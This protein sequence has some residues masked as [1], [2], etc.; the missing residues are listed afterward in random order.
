MSRLRLICVALAVAATLSLGTGDA[1]A[2]SP[3][4]TDCQHHPNGLTQHYSLAEL[5]SALASIPADVREYSGCVN[6]IQTQIF[7][8]STGKLPPATGGSGSSVLVPVIIVLL[9]ILLGGG[10][11]AYLV[12]RRGGGAA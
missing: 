11:A 3:V 2:I 10:G 6:I 12:R 7:R 1:L 8:Q 9:V 5:R 4:L